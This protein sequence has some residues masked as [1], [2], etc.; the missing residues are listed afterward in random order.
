MSSWSPQHFTLQEILQMI[1]QSTDVH[2]AA[3]PEHAITQK[4]NQFTGPP[5]YIGYLAHI[6]S[7]SVQEQDSIRS[8]AAHLLESNARLILSVPPELAQYV[9][10][11]ILQAV[12]DPSVM[13][14]NA[15]SRD[16]VAFLDVLEPKNWSECLQQLVNAL[17]APGDDKQEAAFNVL[18]KACEDYPRKMDMEINGTR[19]S[20]YM[21]PKFLSLSEHPSAKM[22]SHAVACLS[23]F[24]PVNSPSLFVHLDSFIACLFK[25]AS[26]DDPSVR[27]HVCQAFHL[28]LAAQPK[29]LLPEMQN[30]AKFMLSSMKDKD[31]TVALEAC[32]FWR[33]FAENVDLGS[34][35]H[36][37]LGEVVPVL[38]DCMVYGEDDLLW[39]GS[40]AEDDPVPDEEAD[41]KP[42][43]SG[44]KSDGLDHEATSGEPAAEGEQSKNR[45]GANGDDYDDTSTGWNL[46]KCAIAA[47]D[48]LGVHHGEELFNM[49]QNPLKDKLWTTEWQ[50]RESGILALGAI[51]DGCIDFVGTHLPTL[52]PYLINTLNDPKAT[53]WALGR[54]AKWTTRVTADKTLY[55]VPTMEGLLRMVLDNNKHVQEAGCIALTALEKEAGPE[56]I[57]YLD[58][59]L[60]NL[61]FAFDKYQHKNMLVLYDAIGALT[62]AVG[63]ALQNPGYVAI[64]MPPL[65]DQWAKLKDDDKAV[66]PLSAC[67]ASVSIAIG[68]AFIPYAASVFERCKNLIH[69]SLQQQKAYQQNPELD[70]PDKYFLVAALGLLSGLTQGVGMA[71]E[72]LISASQPHLMGLLT[73]CLK[74]PQAPVRQSA[75]ALVGDL[76]MGCFTLLRPHMPGMMQELIMQLD[77]EPKVEFISA[78]NNAAW[79]VGEVA[80]RYGRD[81]TEFQQWVNPLISR[82]IPILLHPKAPR[83]LHENAAVSIGR[84]GLMHPGLVAPRLSEFAQ[85]WC[86]TL[87]ESS[88]NEEKDSAFRAFCT[89]VQTNPTGVLESLLWFCNSIARWEQPSPELNDMFRQLLQGFKARDAGGW[90]VQAASFPPLTRDRLATRYGV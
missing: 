53:C 5:D 32:E 21:I 30:I 90:A 35:L 17:D 58:P 7:S 31:K 47:I 59:V 9:K 2:S 40:D 57:P 12:N 8:I 13:I 68:P 48:V 66:I 39:L 45:L 29:K 78:S 43:H 20:D 26:D 46:R 27:Q 70:E 4:L 22:R 15:A 86:Q 11:A 55:F 19:P 67:L 18:E 61:V 24:V 10:A 52:I 36:P 62:D 77:P 33:I 60:R 41:I 84:I 80:L 1:R 65:T 89:L 76:A 44:G 88:D 85:A 74:H 6:L 71:L 87:C 69:N 14:R 83:S 56:M 42:R 49:L 25:R 37:M 79:S 64:L 28:L 73:D 72:P 3:Q 54:Y 23:H 16:I 51:A 50:E 34:Y 82:L 63:R 38:I 75:Y 81:D